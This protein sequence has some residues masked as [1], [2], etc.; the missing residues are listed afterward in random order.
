LSERKDKLIAGAKLVSEG[1]EPMRLSVKS[2]GEVVKKNPADPDV[3][4]FKVQLEKD[5]AEY[6]A[7][8]EAFSKLTNEQRIGIVALAD[9]S[10]RLTSEISLSYRTNAI[11]AIR[12]EIEFSV[13]DED[14]YRALCEF[15]VDESKKTWARI[16]KDYRRQ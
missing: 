1:A 10:L 11:M 16:S 13:D 4:V 7:K 14:W 9:M 15:E 6:G 2:L 3:E 8:V 5:I 12:E